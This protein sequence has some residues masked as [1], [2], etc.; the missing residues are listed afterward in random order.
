M[1]RFLKPIIKVLVP[2]IYMCISSFACETRENSNEWPKVIG[3]T[4]GGNRNCKINYIVDGKNYSSRFYRPP[5]GRTEV[6]SY[7]IKY[8]P[9]DPSHSEVVYSCPVFLTQEITSTTAGH[10]EKIFNIYIGSIKAVR[11]SYI[12]DGVTYQREQELPLDFETKYPNLKAGE[13]FTV[14][15]LS[16][17]PKRAILVIG[18]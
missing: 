6:E 4:S 8:N 3:Q 10:I 16:T 1:N 18:R 14:R 15:Y 2:V 5:Y 13:T 11:Y 17:N 12:V 7:L 9:E